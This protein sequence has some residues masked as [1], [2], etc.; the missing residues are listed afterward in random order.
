M[1]LPSLLALSGVALARE[2]RGLG[3]SLMPGF[4][5]DRRDF[6]VGQEALPAL[7]VPVEEDPDPKVLGGITE[8]E[9][10]FGSVLLALLGSVQSGLGLSL[11]GW[12]RASGL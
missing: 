2:L 9:R 1:A 5:H 10:A 8:H 11:V 4:L 3:P 6:G 12:E 7:L